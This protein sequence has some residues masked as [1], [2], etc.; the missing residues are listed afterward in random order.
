MSTKNNQKNGYC[1]IM[2]KNEKLV[3]AAKYKSGKKI[4][5]WKSF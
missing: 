1:L 3:S 4:K 2:Y 5:T